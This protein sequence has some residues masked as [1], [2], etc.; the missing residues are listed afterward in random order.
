MAKLTDNQITKQLNKK[1]CWQNPKFESI[2][3]ELVW[4]ENQPHQEAPVQN[5]LYLYNGHVIPMKNIHRVHQTIDQDYFEIY[6][7]EN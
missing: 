1:L 5:N 4:L 7:S 6:T 3:T 2:A